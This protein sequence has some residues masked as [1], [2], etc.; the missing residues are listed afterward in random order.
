MLFQPACSMAHLETQR[1]FLLFSF[2]LKILRSISLFFILF[3]SFRKQFRFPNSAY[4]YR[5]PKQLNKMQILEI[6]VA[7]DPRGVIS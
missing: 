6:F 5:I 1:A 2:Y 3:L 7:L 4:I